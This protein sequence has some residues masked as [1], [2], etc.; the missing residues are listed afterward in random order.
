[1]LAAL[2]LALI[3]PGILRISVVGDLHRLIPQRSEASTGLALSLEG[4]TR[5]DAVY[6]L[7]EGPE[8]R[9]LLLEVGEQLCKALEAGKLVESARFR[10]AE[11]IPDVDPLLLFDIADPETETALLA[12]F[13]EEGA[14]SR[15][16]FAREVLT[17]PTSGDARS[18]C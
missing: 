6:G 14:A 5:S 16:R 4:L 18:S 8:D 15:A 9:K 13:S 11:G 1:M 12:R 10:P 2:A 17:G 7:I 3:V